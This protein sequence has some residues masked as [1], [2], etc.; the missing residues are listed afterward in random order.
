MGRGWDKR[1]LRRR[2]SRFELAVVVA[3]AALII[4]A[5]LWRAPRIM[6]QAEQ[7]S[8]EATLN[9]LRTLLRLQ[10]AHYLI[11]GEREALAAMHYANP[12]AMDG[13]GRSPRKSFPKEIPPTGR[14]RF[15]RG[16]GY[17][18]ELTIPEPWDIDGGNW[19]FDS[20]A[21]VLVYRVAN[22]DYFTSAL[23]G[24]PRARFF[25]KVSYPGS[26][27]EIEGQSGNGFQGVR[28]QPVEP[29]Q[30]RRP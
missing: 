9:N 7:V 20:E 17:I 27:G 5:I 21:R 4:T 14:Y 26:R 1:V 19:Y 18:G 23:Q 30:W 11:Q 22:D 29:Y 8:M 6:V 25:V 2:M 13:D 24:A 15:Y 3:I 10:A 16:G 12:F 28:L